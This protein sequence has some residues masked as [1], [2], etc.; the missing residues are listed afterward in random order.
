[1]DRG[2]R[3][4][5]R[6]PGPGGADQAV[7]DPA[8]RLAARRR[9]AD[10][11]DEAQAQADLR[12]VRRR[13]RGALRRR[14]TGGLSCRRDGGAMPVRQSPGMTTTIDSTT[15]PVTATADALAERLFEGFLST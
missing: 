13:D 2:G 8:G 15:A 9:R 5:Q 10:A 12:E 6:R 7:R 11:D 1:G 4:G 14:L 3:D